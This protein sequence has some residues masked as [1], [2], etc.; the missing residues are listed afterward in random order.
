MNSTYFLCLTLGAVLCTGLFVWK[1]HRGSLKTSAALIALPLAAVLGLVA[2]KVGY[3]LLQLRNQL[4][5]YGGLAALLS[6]RPKEFSFV[7]GALGVVLAVILAARLTRQKALPVLDAF[8]PCG[9]L[10]AAV[11]RACEGLL[12]PMA[13]IGLG[14]GVA[15]PAHCFFPLAIENKS[16]YCWF[17]CVFMLEALLA[18]IC[19]IVSFAVS[20]RG[21]FAPGRVF[22]H[23][24]FF[25]ALPQIF[26]E[27]MLNQYMRWG[28]VRIE[29][30]MCALI[31]L[32][33][34]LYACIKCRTRWAYLPVV[35]M[36]VC[37]GAVIWLEFTLDNKAPFGLDMPPT[38][39]YAL[40][41]LTLCC[42]A[43]LSL[44]SYH[45]LNKVN[46]Q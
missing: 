39:C 29:Q 23:T 31:V 2:S 45:R 4:A 38:A 25:L 17:Y 27:R 12:D 32:A 44:Y 21:R 33:V 46:R 28:F 15:N 11:T 35:L 43:A 6:D 14:E 20:H 36:F 8:A 5:I 26:S 37:A 34:I 1:L 24:A 41:I 9:A 19:A 18:L 16:L 42:M 40:M 10:M 13:M 30:M 3:F 7:C 22:F